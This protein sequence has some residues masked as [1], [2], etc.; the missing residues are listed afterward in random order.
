[1]ATT[2]VKK[3]CDRVCV[4]ENIKCKRCGCVFHQ[5]SDKFVYVTRIHE[6]RDIENVIC[7][8]CPSCDCH[9]EIDETHI[10]SKILNGLRLDMNS[11]RIKVFSCE[12][13]NN[14]SKVRQNQ[15]VSRT[16]G[17]VYTEIVYTVDCTTNT[18]CGKIHTIH[19][20]AV[21]K[22]PE[23]IKSYVEQIS[24]K[25]FHNQKVKDI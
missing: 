15:K 18:R 23:N 20:D 19:P 22:L 10:P 6:N 17:F 13:G 1:M 7:G 16:C 25:P 4:V 24:T 21:R 5:S 11:Q 8:S 3:G 14:L 2:I 9:P 12:Y